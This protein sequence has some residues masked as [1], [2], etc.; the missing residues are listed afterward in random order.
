MLVG[1][2][3]ALSKHFPSEY[4]YR[5][6]GRHDDLLAIRVGGRS[7]CGVRVGVP[8]RNV[9]VFDAIVQ[10][11]QASKVAIAAGTREGRVLSPDCAKVS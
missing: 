6:G 1:A 11:A 2:L 9:L 3:N 4:K 10:D 7:A 5:C 8:L